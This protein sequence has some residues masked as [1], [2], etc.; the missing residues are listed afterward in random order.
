MVL[1]NNGK[2]AKRTRF[3]EFI[4]GVTGIKNLNRFM[5]GFI[6]GETENL[7][8]SFMGDNT[9]CGGK[10]YS[11]GLDFAFNFSM[12]S[13]YMMPV[14]IIQQIEHILGKKSYSS[15]I[16]GDR[17]F[18]KEFAN[19]YGKSLLIFMAHRTRRLLRKDGESV[20][21]SYFKKTQDILMKK[22]F[23]KDYEQIE[24]IEDAKT[25]LNKLRGFETVRAR[26]FINKEEDSTFHDYYDEKF[27]KIIQKLKSKGIQEDEVVKCLEEYRYERQEFKSA[28]TKEREQK[29]KKNI[30]YNFALNQFNDNKKIIDIDEYKF[31]YFMVSPNSGFVCVLK[32]ENDSGFV[33]PYSPGDAYDRKRL[34]EITKKI[35]SKAQEKQDEAQDYSLF[36]CKEDSKISRYLD[37]FEQQ[38]YREESIDF[39]PG[40]IKKVLYDYLKTDRDES[41]ISMLRDE[42]I[43]ENE[44]QSF[45]IKSE[46]NSDIESERFNEKVEKAKDLIK[47]S[48]EQDEEISELE[49]QVQKDGVN[50]DTLE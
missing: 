4:H 44:N 25:Y 22:T 40:E 9:S 16:N 15:I 35:N 20:I 2:E 42:K 24:S 5:I 48:K 7:V 8:E 23:D 47:L 28:Y 50:L 18:E 39:I 12:D 19:K 32:K 3:H 27:R 37:F 34:L 31:K 11:T 46:Q 38:E 17:T 29:E 30:I 1:I 21:Y 43:Q 10:G 13:A 14:A 33:I 36:W 26:V 45:S 6:E 49:K 41:E